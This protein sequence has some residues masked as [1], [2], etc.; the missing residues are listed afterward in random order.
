MPS[1][2]HSPNLGAVLY[3]HT[4][5]DNP[6]QTKLYIHSDKEPYNQLKDI[7][8]DLESVIASFAYDRRSDQDQK[9]KQMAMIA[10]FGGEG[11]SFVKVN[12]EDFNYKDHV[13]SS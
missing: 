6:E 3:L 1:L 8:I 13:I 12:F 11:N 4:N 5:P 10:L 9:A 2:H 7:A